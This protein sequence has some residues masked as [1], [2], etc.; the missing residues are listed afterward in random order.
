MVDVQELKEQPY[1]TGELYNRKTL[2]NMSV[3]HKKEGII[4]V[5][6]KKDNKILFGGTY[7]HLKENYPML[8]V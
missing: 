6:R 1:D 5:K 8:E 3:S 7:A 4:I 2:S